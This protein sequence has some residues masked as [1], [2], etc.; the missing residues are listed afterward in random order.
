MKQWMKVVGGMMTV[1]LLVTRLVVAT[2]AQ[3]PG[4]AGESDGERDLAGSG[5]GHAWGFVDADG[6]GVNDRFVDADGD[7][8][9]DDCGGELGEGQGHGFQD[10]D[11][12]KATSGSHRGGR[13]H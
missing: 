7:G 3:G 6:D 11:G 8:I 2:L 12:D 13:R 4:E 1:A 10:A 5:T 9:C